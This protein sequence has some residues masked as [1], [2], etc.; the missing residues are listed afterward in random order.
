[1]MVWG[2]AS[3]GGFLNTG[4]RYNPGSDSWS[5]VTTS[6]AP[7]PRQGHTAVW[8]GSEM[9]VFGG[10]NNETT[11]GDSYTYAPSRV[12]YLYLKP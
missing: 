10:Y 6:A 12:M 5:E 11:F 4:S 2:G 7:G 9:I 8:S 1:M 3:G